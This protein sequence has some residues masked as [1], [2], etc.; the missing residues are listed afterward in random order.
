MEGVIRAYNFCSKT[1]AVRSVDD[2]FRHRAN[3]AAKV[4]PLT[5]LLVHPQ[6]GLARGH[7]AAAHEAGELAADAEDEPRTAMLLSGI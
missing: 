5:G 1:G 7:S 2:R 6:S 4:A 3:L